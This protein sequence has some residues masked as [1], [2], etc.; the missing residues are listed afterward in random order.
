MAALTW[1]IASVVGGIVIAH[2]LKTDQ[3]IWNKIGFTRFAMRTDFAAG[4]FIGALAMAGIFAVHLLAGLIQ[5][6]SETPDMAGVLFAI[7]LLLIL[8]LLEEVVFRGLLLNGLIYLLKQD[9][10]AVLLCAI[11]FGVAH[12]ENTGATAISVVSNALGGLMYSLA[13][14]RTRRLWL[15]WG[16]HFAWNYFQG[17]V[18]G[19]LVSGFNFG[20]LIQHVTTGDP[21]LTGGAYGPEGGLIGIA[22]R[23]VVIGL[24]LLWTRQSAAA[25]APLQKSDER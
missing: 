23:F 7:P 6:T 16:L 11:L 5:F 18:F 24:I 8:A 17:P 2:W 15:P 13:F 19:F 3:S 25:L 21:L 14:L 1:I 9:T 12:I 22:F 4:V 10:W 20:T